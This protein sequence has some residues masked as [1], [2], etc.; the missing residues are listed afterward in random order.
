[1]AWAGLAVGED[2]G[3]RPPPWLEGVYYH[4]CCLSRTRQFTMAGPQGI[5]WAEINAY[6]QVRGIELDELELSLIFMF[7]MEYRSALAEKG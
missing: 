2:E 3:E 7:D 1:M 4:F 6:Q 5:T